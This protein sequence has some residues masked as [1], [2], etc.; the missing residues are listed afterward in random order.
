MGRRLLILRFVFAL[1]CGLAAGLLVR[2]FFRNKPLFS[3]RE[4]SVPQGRDTDPN[5][6]YRFL[7]NL[8]RNIKATGP[9]FLIGILLT[10][11]YQ[12]YVPGRFI[13]GLFGAKHRGFGVLTAAAL[14][15]PLY[16]CG[17]GTIPLLV[18][19]LQGGMSQGSAVAFMLTGPATK[20][21]N[22]SAL[23]S[24]FTVKNFVIY[25]LFVFFFAAA[26]GLLTDLLL[27]VQ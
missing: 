19:W 7:K 3:F 8:W 21:T 27:P 1:L 23:K 24:A 15:V 18:Q 12:R 13:A 16:V 26:A 2:I 4:N 6:F 17:G 5:L 14:G 20:I 11:L 10:A 25:C 9:Y 22:L